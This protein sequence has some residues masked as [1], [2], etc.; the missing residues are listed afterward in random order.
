VVRE[1]VIWPKSPSLTRQNPR[2]FRCC[3]PFPLL[4]P[5]KKK[6]YC[7]TFPSMSIHAAGTNQA[8]ACLRKWK[9]KKFF[10]SQTPCIYDR[11][12]SDM[13]ALLE[14][15][16]YFTMEGCVDHG[17]TSHIPRSL[18]QTHT[19]GSATSSFG[20][21]VS[22]RIAQTIKSRSSVATL[23]QFAPSIYFTWFNAGGF[24]FQRTKKRKQSS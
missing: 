18:S 20:V 23:Q 5:P 21:E 3:H 19:E 24:V 17:F 15:F 10:M 22:F 14:M 2:I 1:S 6:A 16:H 7:D 13:E 4:P 8:P 11:Q 12:K 9:Q